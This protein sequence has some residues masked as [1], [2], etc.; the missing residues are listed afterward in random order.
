MVPPPQM[1]QM[2]FHPMHQLQMPMMMP[3]MPGMM[4][5]P[6]GPPPGRD[7]DEPTPICRCRVLYLGSAVPHVTKDG[8]QGIQARL[9]FKHTL[10]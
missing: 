4:E 6:P 8:L 5:M 9:F 1:Q 7:D 2:H 3:G 10:V